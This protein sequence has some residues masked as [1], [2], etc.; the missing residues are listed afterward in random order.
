MK[1]TALILGANGKFGRNVARA[2]ENAG[3]AVRRYDRKADTPERAA[4]GAD[5]VVNGMN[6]PNYRGWE[7]H[8]PQIT[9]LGLRAARASG[10]LLIVPGNVYNF[11]HQPAPW[12]PDTPHDPITGKG[13]VRTAMEETLRDA[14]WNHGLRITLLRA[15]DFIDDQPEGTW[16]GEG[17][18]A[19][20]RKGKF[21]YPGCS[22]IPHSWAYLPDL[23]RAV[24]DLAER[25]DDQ[26]GYSDLAFPGYT[27]TGDALAAA[28]EAVSGRPL[29][30]VKFSWWLLRLLSPVIP[31]SA[32]MR[33]MRY[34]W[35]TPH[36]LD[37]TAFFG[38]VPGFRSTPLTTALGPLIGQIQGNA[39]STQTSRC[40]EAEA[41][42]S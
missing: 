35:D 6:P 22:D 12:G 15:G 38:A 33:E 36:S 40:R 42:V 39:I 31:A 27:L 9:D 20:L 29:S 32:G 5:V 37:G 10:A 18:L 1:K 25:R 17:I 30:R 8:V 3:W 14:A 7:E 4:Q 13:Q 24:V 11:G 26:H 23:A 28:C 34:L 19:G 2:F 41:T 21:A 16:L